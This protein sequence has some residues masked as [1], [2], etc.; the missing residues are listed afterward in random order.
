MYLLA[1]K[2]PIIT[3]EEYIQIAIDSPRVVGIYPEIKNPILMNQ[4]VSYTLYISLHTSKHNTSC[5]NIYSFIT[6]GE[7]AKRKEI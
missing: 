5:K 6:I 1:G 3:F 7:M 4:H 2:F